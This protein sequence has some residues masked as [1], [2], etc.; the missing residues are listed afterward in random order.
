MGLSINS[1]RNKDHWRQDMKRVQSTWWSTVEPHR[2]GGR[3]GHRPKLL[4]LAYKCLALQLS[5][6]HYYDTQKPKGAIL[7]PP[8]S[9]ASP[10]FYFWNFFFKTY[11]WGPREGTYEHSLFPLSFSSLVYSLQMHKFSFYLRQY[12]HSWIRFRRNKLQGSAL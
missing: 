7:W 12:L 9:M 10:S 4:S 2:K 1:R 11:I 5:R 8:L 6:V 3:E